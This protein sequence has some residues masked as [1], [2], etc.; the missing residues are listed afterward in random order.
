MACPMVPEH[1]RYASAICR[2]SKIVCIGRNYREHAAETGAE[3]P[4][5]PLIF[6][7]ATSALV[8]P[9]DDLVLPRGSNKTDWEVE[10]GVVLKQAVRYVRPDEALGYVAGYVLCNDV[11][12]REYQKERGGQWV[13]GKS[14]DG[15]APVGP[16]LCTTE[17]LDPTNLRLWL[18]LNGRMM[19]DGNTQDMIFD[20]ATLISYISQFM[21]LLPGDLISTGT[22]A[23]VGAGQNPPRFLREGDVIQCGIEGLGTATRR[24]VS[25]TEPA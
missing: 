17:E 23:G 13:K 16:Y 1:A 22:P 18:E 14:S 3:V 12:E 25:R 19:Q 11:S 7:K 6:L 24:V 20:V 4:S 5:E 8:G 10:L 15:F 9:N 21:T 2:P